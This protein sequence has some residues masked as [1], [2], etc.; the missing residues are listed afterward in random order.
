MIEWWGPV[1]HEYYSGTEAVCFTYTSSADWL[2]HKGTV[3]RSLVGEPHVLDEDGE[4]L[5]PGSVG[6]LYFSGGPSFEYH[7]G[8]AKTAASRDPKG[9]GWATLGDVGYVD[10]DGFL[11]LTDGV[12]HMIISGG[13]NVYPPEAQNPVAGHPQGAHPAVP[14]RP[15]PGIGEQG[16]AGPPP[17]AD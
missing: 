13:G 8:P 9:R 10:D 12:S 4:E 2:A 14:G 7:G 1:L 11:Y 5:P 17:T 3:G 15:D 16:T 6:T